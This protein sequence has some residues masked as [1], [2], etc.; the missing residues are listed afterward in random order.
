[1]GA[2]HRYTP[3]GRQRSYFAPFGTIADRTA[4]T[5]A[6]LGTATEIG[7]SLPNA[8]AV[9]RTANSVDVSDPSSK[10]DKQQAGT[11]GGETWTFQAYQELTGGDPVAYDTLTEDVQGDIVI[12]R[13]GIAG[14]APAAGEV[15]TVVP[16]VVGA[17]ADVDSGRNEADRVAISVFITDDI[18]RDAI[19][20]A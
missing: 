13:Q 18:V 12:F 2:E 1:M 17:V 9:P 3:T 5:V 14:A 7:F 11:R 4:P 16:I 20:A 6:E 15:C 19:V 8:L 10:Q